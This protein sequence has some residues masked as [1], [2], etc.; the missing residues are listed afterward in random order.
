MLRDKINNEYFEWMYGMLGRTN[1]RKLLSYLHSVPFKYSISNDSNRVEDG[2]AL[3]LR[4]AMERDVDE[5]LLECIDYSCTVLE[6]MV[7]LAVKCEEHIMSDPDIGDRTAQWF[8]IMVTNLG[9]ISMTDKRFDRRYVEDVI[10][11]FLDRDYEPDGTGS[12]FRIKNC[13]YDLR[14]VEIWYQMNFYL[15]DICS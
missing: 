6:M 10:F 13:K 3:R 12:L 9:L 1:Y 4:F 5:E 7:A 14:D 8:W 11:R 2:L 15:N